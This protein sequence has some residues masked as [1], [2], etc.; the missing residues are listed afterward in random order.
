MTGADVEGMTPD[1]FSDR[2][3]RDRQG[4]RHH[5]PIVNPVARR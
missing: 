3:P 1:R 2:K 4:A 5:I